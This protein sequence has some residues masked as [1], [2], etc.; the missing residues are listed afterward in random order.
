ML[1]ALLSNVPEE[2]GVLLCKLARLIELGEK[3]R[4]TRGYSS[5]NSRRRAC[6]PGMQKR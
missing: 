1:L 6:P 2:N 5:G 4:K 3:D